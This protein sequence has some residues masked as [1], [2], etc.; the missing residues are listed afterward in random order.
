VVQ[1]LQLQ[2]PARHSRDGG[3]EDS[4]VAAHRSFAHHPLP[5]SPLGCSAACGLPGC[6]AQL[7]GAVLISRCGWVD[8]AGPDSDDGPPGPIDLGSLTHS[9]P[10]AFGSPETQKHSQDEAE[11]ELEQPSPQLAHDQEV[12]AMATEESAAVVEVEQEHQ[13]QHLQ[14]K[15]QQ[16][17]DVAAAE[18]AATTAEVTMAEA[19]TASAMQAAY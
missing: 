19:A 14:L 17:E 5:V 15:H 1:V 11:G 8:R 7:A 4:C 2:K 9:P 12:T 6:A 16:G 3:H 18:V 13:Q 10:L